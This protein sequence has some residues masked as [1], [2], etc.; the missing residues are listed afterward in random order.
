MKTKVCKTEGCGEHSVFEFY[1]R[2][3]VPMPR[4]KN[5][6]K[7]RRAVL[8]QKEGRSKPKCTTCGETDPE[9]FHKSKYSHTGRQNICKVC[10]AAENLA[11]R[12]KR[13]NYET[14]EAKLRRV[15][16]QLEMHW[17]KVGLK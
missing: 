1:F 11:Q 8:A 12:I 2:N 10:R 4:C 16:M 14:K 13:E 17:H 6:T 7:K 15:Y 5:C 3:G 9:K